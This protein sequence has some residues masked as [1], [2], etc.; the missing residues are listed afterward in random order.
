MQIWLINNKLKTEVLYSLLTLYIR[1][2]FITFSLKILTDI[3]DKSYK[4]VDNKIKTSLI[5]HVQKNI[6]HEDKDYNASMKMCVWGEG[7][8]LKIQDFLYIDFYVN[9]FFGSGSPHEKTAPYIS[10][11]VS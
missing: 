11:N 3:N 1:Q 7:G 2:L 10:S 5:R 8:F 9:L 4:I 6:Y